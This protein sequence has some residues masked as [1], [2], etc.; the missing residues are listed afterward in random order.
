[1]RHGYYIIDVADV[2]HNVGDGIKGFGMSGKR[3]LILVPLPPAM[4]TVF[5]YYLSFLYFFS[6]FKRTTYYIFINI[7]L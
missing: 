7:S 2:K 4:I 6:N 5:M 1:M 3:L